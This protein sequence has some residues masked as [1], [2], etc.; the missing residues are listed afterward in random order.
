MRSREPSKLKSHIQRGTTHPSS[1]HPTEAVTP[2]YW[3]YGRLMLHTN[4]PWLS[5]MDSQ[6]PEPLWLVGSNRLAQGVEP[7][8]VSIAIN[9]DQ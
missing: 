1:C 2:C 9:C 8:P 7:R 3:P 5:E 4:R 6:A